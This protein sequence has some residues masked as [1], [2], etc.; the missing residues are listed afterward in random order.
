MDVFGK[1]RL[2]A[3]AAQIW[4]D[5]VKEFDH[6]DVFTALN[7]W[8]QYNSKPPIPADIWRHLNEKRTTTLEEKAKSERLVNTGRALPD[9]YAPTPEGKALFKI[10]RKFLGQKG[11]TIQQMILDEHDNYGNMPSSVVEWAREQ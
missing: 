6:N 5:S 2:T 8:P 3:G 11:K 10:M 4:W 7:F 9:D 1:Q